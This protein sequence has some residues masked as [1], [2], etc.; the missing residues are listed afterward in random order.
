VY[1]VVLAPYDLFPA[2]AVQAGQVTLLNNPNVVEVYGDA[3][4]QRINS[5]SLT[6]GSTLRFNGLVFNDNGTLRV[7][8]AQVREGVAQ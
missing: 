1:T 7:D 5:T 8:C 6:P 2:L 3:S 4:T